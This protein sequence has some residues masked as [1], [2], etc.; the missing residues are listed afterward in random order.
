L[1][2]EVK[3]PHIGVFFKS[4]KDYQSADVKNG[5]AWAIWTSETHVMAKKKAENQTGSLTPDH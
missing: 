1:I 2:A 4:L 3:T 5:I